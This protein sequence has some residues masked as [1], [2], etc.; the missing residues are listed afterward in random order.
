MFHF[1]LENE[2]RFH[3]F[4]GVIQGFFHKTIDLIPFY[5]YNI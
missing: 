1:L 5:L 4:N 3:A 2:K